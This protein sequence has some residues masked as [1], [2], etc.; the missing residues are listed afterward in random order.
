MSE[1]KYL[2]RAWRDHE[3]SKEYCHN[4]LKDRVHNAKEISY[5]FILYLQASDSVDASF[6]DI[7]K[8]HIERLFNMLSMI[9]KYF[10]ADVAYFTSPEGH[11]KIIQLLNHNDLDITFNEESD[12]FWQIE[13]EFS[14]L[15]INSIK[16]EFEYF[17]SN[18]KE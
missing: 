14:E 3:Y 8:N 2:E 18:Q 1:I 16:L 4:Y 17:I 5:K 11:S 6:I 13:Y 12:P 7:Q 15:G 10:S 9:R